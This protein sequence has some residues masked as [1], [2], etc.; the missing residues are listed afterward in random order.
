MFKGDAKW[1]G[2]TVADGKVF[3]TPFNADKILVMDFATEDFCGIDTELVF[4][5]KG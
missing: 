4:S 5:G 2:T 3:A 1:W